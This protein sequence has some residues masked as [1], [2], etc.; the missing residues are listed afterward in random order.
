MLG[1]SSFVPLVLALMFGAVFCVMH[2]SATEITERE[3]TGNYELLKKVPHDSHLFTQGLLFHKGALIESAGL[4]KYS[5]LNH[6]VPGTG[7]VRRQIGIPADLFAEG[8]TIIDDILY[9]LTWRE[10]KVLLFD[11]NSFKVNLLYSC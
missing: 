8:I 4:Y 3:L 2:M 1:I 7:I 9:M 11:A 10:R 5:T 6:I